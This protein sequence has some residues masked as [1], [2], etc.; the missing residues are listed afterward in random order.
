MT[1]WSHGSSTGYDYTTVKYN[2]DGIEQWVARY[3]APGNSW[4]EATALVGDGSGNVYVTGW[5]KGP[6]TGYDYATVKYDSEGTELWVARYDASYLGP[7]NACDVATALAVDAS[8]NVY[9]AGY[10]EDP[11]GSAWSVYSTIKY[12]QTYGAEMK[13]DVNCDGI[14]NIL[15]V[16]RVVNIILGDPAAEHERWA[17]DCN[18]DGDVNIL[19]V[20]EIVNIILGI[21]TC[22]PT[23]TVKISPPVIEYLKSLKPYFSAED[24]SRFMA[25]VKAEMHTPDEYHL[26]QNYPNPFNPATTITFAL[27]VSGERGLVSRPIHTTLKIFNILGQEVRTLVDEPQE[28]GYYTVTWDGKDSFG[29]DVASGVYFY[30]L[31]VD[32]GQWSKT[33]RML[34]LK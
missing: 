33:K 14:V 30:R 18:E 7:A 26:A 11:Q 5:S 29:N 12:V 20:V 28:A 23:G 15:D 8:R 3:N 22:P 27:P 16:V 32:S 31:I 2:T 24:F 13:D 21:G 9:V 10:S 34:L 1:G 6:G 25:L 17:A 19:D 4:A